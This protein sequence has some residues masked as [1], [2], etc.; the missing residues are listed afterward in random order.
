MA[1]GEWGEIRVALQLARG[2]ARTTAEALRSVQ[3][4]QIKMRAVTEPDPRIA[5]GLSPY[6]SRVLSL[7]SIHFKLSLPAP[8]EVM[9]IRDA[10]QRILKRLIGLR[11]QSFKLVADAVVRKVAGSGRGD[12]FG[13]V[14][15]QGSKTIYLNETYFSLTQQGTSQTKPNPNPFTGPRTG[16]VRGHVE[17]EQ[18]GVRITYSREIRAGVILHETVHLCYGADGAIHRALRYGANVTTSNE[19]CNAGYPQIK[20]YNAAIGDAYVYERFAHCVYQAQ[21]NHNP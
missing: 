12:V 9:D 3:Q 21:K 18:S 13:Y 8:Q 2:I 14:I 5:S 17:V 15:S 20:D 4:P 19:D 10:Y 1:T 11:R 7:L 16:A 6:Q